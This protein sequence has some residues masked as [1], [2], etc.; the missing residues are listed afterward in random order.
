MLE[1]SEKY[2]G[3]LQD[4]SNIQLSIFYHDIVYMASKND[5][6]EQSAQMAS[7]D[8]KMFQLSYNFV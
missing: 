6:E 1:A 2:S 5:N 4:I 7:S 3:K 8:L